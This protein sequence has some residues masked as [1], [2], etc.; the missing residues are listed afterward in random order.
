MRSHSGSFMTF[1][2]GM[3]NGSSNKPKINT[4]SSTEAEILAVH[5]NMPSV[6]WT[7]Y[8]LEEQGYPLKPTILHQD[9]QSSILLETNGWASSSKQ[10]R[11]M[12]IR[13]FFISDCVKRKHIE[14]AYCPTDDM[15]GD[16]FTKPLSGGKFRRFRNIIMNCDYDEYGAVD[17]SELMAHQ[18]TEVT[19][20]SLMNEN[21]V[22]KDSKHPEPQECVGYNAKDMGANIAKCGQKLAHNKLVKGKKKRVTHRRVAP[23]RAVAE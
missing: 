9:N 11:H 21:R 12:N 7:R 20:A 18:P 15:I 10:T 6:L 13:Y 16:F 17:K 14:I 4:T 2:K 1:G 22:T 8:F 5:D 3:I 23:P 19:P